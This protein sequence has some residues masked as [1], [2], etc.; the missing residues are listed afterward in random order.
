[1]FILRKGAHLEE[2]I[3]GKKLIEKYLVLKD[4]INDL[5]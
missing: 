3:K 5:L 2:D 1:M 4:S